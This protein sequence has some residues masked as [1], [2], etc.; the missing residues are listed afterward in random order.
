MDS[1]RTEQMLPKGNASTLL[2]ITPIRGNEN[3]IY[4]HSRLIIPTPYLSSIFESQSQTLSLD[5][6]MTL[7]ELFSMH[8]TLRGP[9]GWLHEKNMHISMATPITYFWISNLA[10]RSYMYSANIRLGS[11][12]SLQTAGSDRQSFYWL[13]FVANFEGV[14][15]VLVNGNKIFALQAT[16]AATHNGPHEGLRKIWKTIGAEAAQQFEWHFVI[17][18]DDESLAVRYARELGAELNGFTLGHRRLKVSV[19]TCVLKRGGSGVENTGLI[20]GCIV[21]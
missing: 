8:P 6:M 14:D 7:Y 9:A 13:P 4:S 15:G 12:A 19:W 11:L 16:I 17:V 2:F 1:W 3:L 5:A 10:R 18:T 20:S 21:S